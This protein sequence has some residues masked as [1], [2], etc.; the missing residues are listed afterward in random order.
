MSNRPDRLIETI[1]TRARWASIAVCAALIVGL[2]IA[3]A[4]RT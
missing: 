3:G 1:A 4:W 2:A